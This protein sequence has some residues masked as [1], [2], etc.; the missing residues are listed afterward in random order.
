VIGG[1]STGAINAV[2]MGMYSKG[3]ETE[4]AKNLT[5]FWN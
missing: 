1:L 2:G 3:Q 4:M 5:N